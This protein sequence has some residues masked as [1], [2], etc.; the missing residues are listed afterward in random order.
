MQAIREVAIPVCHITGVRLINTTA[1]QRC[2]FHSVAEIYYILL[3]L[4]QWHLQC[5]VH[6]ILIAT[7][8]RFIRVPVACL[9][10]DDYRCLVRLCLFLWHFCLFC[11]LCISLCV[12][13]IFR[14]W[15][16]YHVW[17][18]WWISQHFILLLLLLLFRLFFYL[19]ELL[20]CDYHGQSQIPESSSQRKHS[21][22]W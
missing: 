19:S 10:F 16:I 6:N 13:F 7:T 18:F 17:M 2:V 9:N 3:L 21:R 4:L 20:S 15:L 14:R 12:V 5:Y 11:S 22:D 1:F 8:T